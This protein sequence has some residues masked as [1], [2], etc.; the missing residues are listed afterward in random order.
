MLR[1][2]FVA[3]GVVGALAAVMVGGSASAQDDNGDGGGGVTL[4]IGLTQDLDSPN[5]T[6]GILVSAFEL[7]NLQYATLTDKAADDFSTIPGLAESWEVSDDGL[8][9]TY[10][11]RDGLTWSDGEPLTADDVA[12]TINRSRDEE[13]LNHSITTGNL[14]ATAID[15]LTLEVVSSVPDPKLPALDAYIVPQHVYEAIPADDVTT[16]DGLDGV[17]AGPYVLDDWQAG[18][19]WTMV[20]NPNYWGWDE[21]EPVIDRVVF[22][23]FSNGDAMAAALEQGEIDA[24]HNVPP[25]AFERLDEDPD[26]VAVA[27]E[28]GGFSELAMNSGAGGIGDGHPALTDREFRRAL[29]V[30]IDREALLE[31]VALGL[32]SVGEAM[33][34]SANPEWQ[35]EIP[36]DAALTHD[37]DRANQ[38]LDDAGYLDTDGDG[39]REMP[40]GGDPIELRYVQRSESVEEPQ[41]TELVTGWLDAVGIATTVEVYD[42]TQLT[43]VVAAGDF[44]LFSWGWTPYVD[45]DTQLA[46]LTCDQV[47]T[48]PDE[49]Y[50]AN[51]ANWCNEEYDELYEQQKVELDPDRR[52]EL[53][54][55]ALLV[56]Y[57]DAPYVVYYQSADLQAYRTDRFEGWLHQPA[58]VG[59]V[60]FSNS[61]PT[62]A[63]LSLVDGADDAGGGSGAVVVGALA[64]AV[65]AV[66]AGGYLATRRRRTADDRE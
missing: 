12:Y 53:V 15:D 14:D 49:A 29:T 19:S 2:Q 57:A 46:Y 3:V 4:T 64:A 5:V 48:D 38:M 59:P 56:L 25:S 1:R 61:S 50:G 8:T 27:G 37:P 65:V 54:Q 35:P 31:R 9:V 58:E 34:V 55:E 40:D 13:W 21:G 62:Y 39:V 36:D 47:T 11:L 20:A 32:G 22:R 66:G 60:L 26:I 23:V 41:L 63:N 18:E 30:A 24:A 45:P 42:D 33:V 10:T 28:Q 17:G 52:R 44:D 16:Y 43:D 51:D 6:S 7:W